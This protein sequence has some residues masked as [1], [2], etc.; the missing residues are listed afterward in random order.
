MKEK[1]KETVSPARC[2]RDNRRRKAIKSSPLATT[3][4]GSVLFFCRRF[5]FF[6]YTIWYRRTVESRGTN[7][8]GDEEVRPKNE[9]KGKREKR[10][11]KKKRQERKEENRKMLATIP[12]QVTVYDLHRSATQRNQKQRESFEE[13]LARCYSCIKRMARMHQTSCTYIVPHILFGKPVFDVNACIAFM[14]RNLMG[15]GFFVKCPRHNPRILHISW[16]LKGPRPS[17]AHEALAAAAVASSSNDELPV[18]VSIGTTSSTVR[19]GNEKNNN[20]KRSPSPP[21]PSS[22]PSSPSPSPASHNPIP[23]IPPSRLQSVRQ[24]GNRPIERFDTMT[25]DIP[26]PVSLRTHMENDPIMPSPPQTTRKG[27]S[28][29]KNNAVDQRAAAPVVDLPLP[30]HD[31]I[32][33]PPSLFQRSISTFKPSGKFS[34]RL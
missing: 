12:T 20:T 1:R 6:L 3:C 21:P 5:S 11:R 19:P 30:T 14:I 26:F 17:S 13:V 22:P 16:D 7:E 18:P 9:R 29:K 23:H 32:F 25:N 2:N 4:S 31:G 15:N 27:R 28:S 33:P 24:Y 10:K 8:R 34:L